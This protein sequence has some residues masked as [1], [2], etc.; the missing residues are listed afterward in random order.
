MEFKGEYRHPDYDVKACQAS[1]DQYFRPYPVLGGSIDSE[2]WSLAWAQ[3]RMMF[4]EQLRGCQSQLRVLSID[5]AVAALRG[6]SV[7]GWPWSQRHAL[8]SQL[9]AD[10]V[11]MRWYSEVFEP[12]FAT[13]TPVYAFLT[14]ALKREPR[15]FSKLDAPSASAPNGVNQ[16]IRS[17]FGDDAFRVLMCKRLCGSFNDAV[18]ERSYNGVV[19][20]CFSVVGM[21]P[22]AGNFGRMVKKFEGM[23]AYE[24]D[25]KKW[26]A[27]MFP[28]ALQEIC[29]LR[30]ALMG[31]AY[32]EEQVT[33]LQ[34]YYVSITCCLIVMPDGRVVWKITGQPS[35]QAN[36]TIDNTIFTIFVNLYGFHVWCMKIRRPPTREFIDGYATGDI[37]AVCYGD[38]NNLAFSARVKMDIRELMLILYTHLYLEFTVSPAGPVTSLKWFNFG[39]VNVGPPFGWLPDPDVKRRLC[40]LDCAPPI[41]SLG[42]V[43]ER[44]VGV[45]IYSYGNRALYDYINAYLDWLEVRVG[46]RS[47]LL[48]TRL[49]EYDVISIYNGIRVYQTTVVDGDVL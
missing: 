27:S 48:V 25:G 7:T 49:S 4:A 18:V 6:S 43:Y 29:R 40:T 32:N 19:G 10:P 39:F 2:A 31:K 41:Y 26:D 14:Q 30:V 38:D 15:H 45:M 5:E 8:K 33:S 12:S 42:K 3:T 24:L 13:A 16:A 22:F 11:C 36:T 47:P 20:R 1:V 34:N 17:V 37:V 23:S 9:Y 28:A 35:G 21:S 46:R 44:A